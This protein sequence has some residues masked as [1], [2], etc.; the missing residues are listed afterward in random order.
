MDRCGFCV[1]LVILREQPVRFWFPNYPIRLQG[2]G[3]GGLVSWCRGHCESYM[4][5][6]KQA[7]ALGKGGMKTLRKEDQQDE[8]Q[9]IDFLPNSPGHFGVSEKKIANCSSQKL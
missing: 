1:H 5:W 7:V 8:P 3:S 9:W 2:E 4:A 6:N